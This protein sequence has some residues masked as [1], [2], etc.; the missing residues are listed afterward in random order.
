MTP[1]ITA[2]IY[3]LLGGCTGVRSRD[4]GEQR[5]EH[6]RDDEAAVLPAERDQ[7][8]P[9]REGDHDVLTGGRAGPCSNIRERR[10]H[11]P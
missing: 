5:A 11:E 10:C 4:E 1:L 8:D 9:G 2:L 6:R 7:A 3:V